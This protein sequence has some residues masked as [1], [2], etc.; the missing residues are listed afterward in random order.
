[1]SPPYSP[2]CPG[3][4]AVALSSGLKVFLS[5]GVL[6]LGAMGASPFLLEEVPV[7]V[8]TTGDGLAAAP[9]PTDNLFP[10]TLPEN[11]VAL[12]KEPTS[13]QLAE[14]SAKVAK[15]YPE[16]ILVAE[17]PPK[18][19]P[20]SATERSTVKLPTEFVVKMVSI[21]PFASIH[22]ATPSPTAFPA[23][24]PILFPSRP[25][26]I[27]PSKIADSLLP[28]FHFA[29][30]SKPLSRDEDNQTPPEN[31]FRQLQNDTTISN[32]NQ[33]LSPLRPFVELRPLRL[34]DRE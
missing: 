3:Q 20:S 34:A 5:I 15:P 4:G 19:P 2:H 17:A 26:G 16:P 1:M 14:I 13:P 12:S 11:P 23:R 22:S 18:S 6:F 21:S 30:N 25:E 7:S 31:P 28:M 29:E 27:N 24:T 32:D 33:E 8:P 10:V 9:L